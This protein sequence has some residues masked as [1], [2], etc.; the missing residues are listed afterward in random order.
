MW[1]I[2]ATLKN[3][4]VWAIPIMMVAGVIFGLLV[5]PAFL[6][7]AVMPLTL[8]MVYP[9]M[10]NLR[11]NQLLSREDQAVQWVAQLINFGLIPF[12]AYGIGLLFF[13][14][15][16]MLTLG[17]LLIALLPTS[18][19]TISWTGFAKGNVNAA[20]KLT[21]FSLILGALAAPIYAKVLLGR[22]IAIPLW[23]IFKQIGLV[24][25][26]PMLFGYLTRVLLVRQYGADT[27]NQ[28]FKQK[29][30][31]L[32]VVGVLGIVFVV[33][34]LKAKSIVA[35]PVALLTYLVPLLLFYGINYL[36]SG[37]IGRYFFKREDGIAL[38]YGTAIR[39][40]SIALAIALT[41]FGGNGSDIAIIIAMAFVIQVQSAVWT[42]RLVDKL[43][44]KTV[45]DQPPTLQQTA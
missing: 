10:V 29:F 5:E 15:Q 14:D 34:A 1:K 9:M 19:M 26:V 41:A 35:D 32:S 39:Q 24:I 40:L 37:L 8:L 18:G 43:F 21:V 27:Y 22:V 17:L 7:S 3:N 31:L 28:R 11:L 45:R 30:P 38:V 6:K 2:L 12:I 20:V 4:L 33:M 42:V 13:P 16:P 25:F 23:T 44:G 36:M